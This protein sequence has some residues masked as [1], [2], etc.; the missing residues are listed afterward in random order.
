MHEYGHGINYD[1]Y[2]ALGDPG[3]MNNGAMHEGYADLW[4]ITV[5]DNPIMGQG[6]FRWCRNKR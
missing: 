1:L 6:F 4:G 5:T 3:G 2:A